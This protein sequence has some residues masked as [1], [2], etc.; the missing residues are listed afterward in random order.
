MKLTSHHLDTIK[1]REKCAF[2]PP[3]NLTM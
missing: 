3:R 2:P 1:Y